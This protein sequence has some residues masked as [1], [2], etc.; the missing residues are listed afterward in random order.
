MAN[1]NLQLKELKK[2]LNLYIQK[3]AL[4]YL[5][6]DIAV[7]TKKSQVEPTQILVIGLFSAPKAPKNF[8]KH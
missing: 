1:H 7:I 3:N 8:A 2:L 6:I 4:G 5:I